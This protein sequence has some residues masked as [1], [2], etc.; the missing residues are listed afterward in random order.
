MKLLKFFSIF[1]LI[2]QTSLNAQISVSEDPIDVQ[3]YLFEI[4]VNDSTDIIEGTATV[5]LKIKK[6]EKFFELDLTS[7]NKDKKGMQVIQITNNNKQVSFQHKNNKIKIQ[8]PPSIINDSLQVFH[9]KYKG[10]PIDG[11]IISKNKYGDRTFFGDNWPTRARNWLPCNDEISDK[12][13]VDFIV[14]APDYYQVVS[15]GTLIE[16]TNLND[17]LKLFHYTSKI[18]LSTYLMVVGISRFSV[19]NLGVFNQIP[20]STWVYPQNKEEGF[21]DYAQAIEI[22]DYF[23][24]QIAPFPYSK[25]ANVQSKTRFGGMENA[26]AIFY[27]ERSVTGKRKIETLLAHEIAHQWFGDSA[28]EKKWSHLWLSE[29]FATYF[30]N[31]YLEHKYGKER[32]NERLINERKKI[33]RFY[34]KQQTPV[35]DEDQK[36]YMKLLNTNS[37]EK[38]GWVLHMLRREIGDEQFWKSIKA[39]YQKYKFDNALTEDFK[40]VVEEISHKDLTTFFNQWLYGVGQPDLN[41]QWK[42]NTNEVVISVDQIQKT[43]TIFK[44]PLELLIKFEDGTTKL[45]TFHI[46]QKEKKFTLPVLS[47]VTKIIM[48]PNISLLYK[49]SNLQ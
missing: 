3:H 14:I 32:L 39:Y 38:G 43:K 44:F 41:L 25:L 15:N 49:T 28:T 26:G 27:S 33:I 29:G 13:L 7:L 8:I 19:Q 1:L 34:E 21:Y 6:T 9:I 36:N 45:K 12:A 30:T 4:K 31:L 40:K 48:D 22:V 11:L 35:I 16:E 2:V 24:K 47:Q 17:H 46:D 10:I 5:S 18:P 42:N 20:I 37:Y 23:V